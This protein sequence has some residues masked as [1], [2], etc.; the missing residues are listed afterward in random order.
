MEDVAL[1]KKMALFQG[2]DALE[3]VQVSKRIQHRKAAA[4]EVVAAQ[5][6]RGEALFIV[7]SGKLVVSVPHHDSRE[8]LADLGPGQHF[9]EV[10]LIDHGPRSAEVKALT[11][12][13]LLV[14]DE[15]SFKELLAFSP[16]LRDK[17]QSN[18]LLDLCGKIRNTNDRLLQML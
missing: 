3:M 18:L 12:T 15:K 16:E 13:E 14:L 5:G 4:Y 6:S 2:L 1:L 10:S 7:R 11:D 8:I 17:L 9:G